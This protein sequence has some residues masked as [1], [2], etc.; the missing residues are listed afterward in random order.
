MPRD[1]ANCGAA[2]CCSPRQLHDRSDTMDH[3]RKHSSSHRG[4]T[5][6]ARTDAHQRPAILGGG[7]VARRTVRRR[8][9]ALHDSTRRKRVASR[10]RNSLPCRD[11]RNRCACGRSAD[12]RVAATEICCPVPLNRAA[13]RCAFRALCRACRRSCGTTR[14]RWIHATEDASVVGESLASSNCSSH[15][16]CCVGAAFVRSD[17]RRVGTSFVRRRREGRSMRD[18]DEN[19]FCERRHYCQISL[20]ETSCDRFPAVEQHRRRVTS[21]TLL[22]LDRADIVPL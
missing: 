7:C 5:W 15:P 14:V 22:S 19:I 17:S 1:S 9:H 10:F 11:L 12:V 8:L 20:R 6:L 16:A 18:G 3:P 2:H 21:P 4:A 13:A